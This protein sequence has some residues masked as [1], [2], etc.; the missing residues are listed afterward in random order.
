MTGGCGRLLSTEAVSLLSLSLSLSLSPSL[1]RTSDA[2]SP[3]LSSSLSVPALQILTVCFVCV[4][5]VV[6]RFKTRLTGELDST[7]PETL[8]WSR[9]VGAV[10]HGLPAPPGIPG[11]HR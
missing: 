1:S 3:L 10:L 11:G 6:Q 7:H 4:V 9:E 2:S 5:W 8:P